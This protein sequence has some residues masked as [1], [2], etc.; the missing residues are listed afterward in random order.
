LGYR[1]IAW[2]R[3]G[4][5]LIELTTVQEGWLKC[6]VYGSK[7]CQREMVDREIAKEKGSIEL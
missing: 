5:N 7:E 6:S 2:M 4:I 3:L 1:I